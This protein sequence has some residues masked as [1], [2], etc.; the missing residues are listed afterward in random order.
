MRTL[1]FILI[2]FYS[3]TAW[4]Q[5]TLRVMHYNLLNFGNNTGYCNQT[6]N[7]YQDKTGYLKTIVAYVKPDILT[8]NEISNSTLYHEYILNNALNVDGISY[9]Q[10]GNPPNFSNSYIIN[11]I[12]YNSEKLTLSSSTSISTNYRDID[13]FRM[14]FTYSGQQN[15]ATLNCVVA[16]LKAGS[17]YEDEVERASETNKLMNYLDNS[18]A[19]GNY[20]FSGDFNLYTSSEQA[21][22]NLLFYSNEDIR[23]YDPVNEIGAW[24]NNPYFADV[25]TQSTHTSSNC[26]SGG[27]MDDR[28]D[29]IL[30]SDEVLNGTDKMKYIANTYKALG[31]DGQ[32][33]NKSLVSSPE[34]T[35]VPEDVLY[36]LYGLS[37]H[38][39]VVMEMLVGDNLGFNDQL[40]QNINISF[41]NPVKDYL[42]ITFTTDHPAEISFDLMGI[43]GN[44][45][46]SLKAGRNSG[47]VTIPVS[48][49]MKGLYLLKIS[50]KEGNVAFRKV[51]KL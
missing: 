12:F 23:F 10:K 40:F 37:D 4:S 28:F 1:I 42:E 38:L 20:I 44:I 11:Q 26:F 46:F 6:N 41:R 31:Q 33:F 35:L 47:A 32:H 22:K 3:L 5:D 27:G 25:H 2:G 9:Y 17:D 7:N 14:Q 24:N 18:N 48:S 15:P 51:I 34:N 50:D 29:F 43:Y 19:T 21:F 39:P 49:L 13:I 8:V 45:L 36:A 30:A 16:H